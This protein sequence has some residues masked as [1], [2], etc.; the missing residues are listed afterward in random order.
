MVL[1]WIA[2]GLLLYAFIGSFLAGWETDD[3]DD[4]NFIAAIVMFWPII[5]TVYLPIIFCRVVIDWSRAIHN[6]RRK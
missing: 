5:Y 2:L 3:D 1:V 4:K 6:K